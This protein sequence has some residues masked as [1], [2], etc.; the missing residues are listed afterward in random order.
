MSREPS[1]TP[2]RTQPVH[3]EDPVTQQARCGDPRGITGPRPNCPRCE[4]A[5][6]LPM[7]FEHE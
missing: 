7:G 5:K 1:Q 4:C 3:E 6:H 2:P